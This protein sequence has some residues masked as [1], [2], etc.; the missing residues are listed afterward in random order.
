MVVPVQWVDELNQAVLE[1]LYQNRKLL[2][3]VWYQG[4]QN[5]DQSRLPHHITSA[6]HEAK[7]AMGD[8]S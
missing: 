3:R 7:N 6:R 2:H 4:T 1:K 8:Q 5:Q